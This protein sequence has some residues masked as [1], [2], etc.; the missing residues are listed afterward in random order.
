MA[1]TKN[2]FLESFFVR[3]DGAGGIQGA[4]AEYLEIIKDG[5]EE[6][7]RRVLPAQPV[8]LLP[9]ALAP[10]LNDALAGALETNTA[11]AAEIAS[12]TAAK[13]TEITALTEAKAQADSDHE[14]VLADLT[15]AKNGEIAAITEAKAKADSDRDNALATVAEMREQLAV[16]QTTKDDNGVPQRVPMADAQIVLL[17]AGLLQKVQDALDAMPS[18]EGDEARIRW[19]K[20]Q[21]IRRDNPLVVSVQGALGMTDADIDALFVAAAKL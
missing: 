18:P 13:N 17:R 15:A 11:L 2:T 9:A 10:I 19:A 12:L 7:A 4:H 20:D 14:K 16:Y 6:I 1:L 3:G 5:D 21:Y 8:A